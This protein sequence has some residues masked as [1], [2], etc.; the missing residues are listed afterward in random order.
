MPLF[1]P[2]K[3]KN[4]IGKMFRLFT[5]LLLMGSAVIGPVFSAANCPGNWLG[6]LKVAAVELRVV[7]RISASTDGSLMAVMD[8]PDQGAKNI[9]VDKVDCTSTGLKL[10]VAGIR[11]SFEGTFGQDGNTLSG[12]WQQG[13]V[14]IPLELKRVQEV[15]E[16]KRPQTP[17]KPYPYKEEE[18]VFENK[19]AGVKLAGTLTM[20]NKQEPV[21]GVILLS[22]SGPQDRDETIFN[23]KPFW[24][25]AD[26]LT[27]NGI[28]VLRFDDRGIGKSTGDFSQA[29]TEDF[30]GDALAAVEFLK[31]RKEIDIRKIGLIGHSEGGL[32]APLAA[33][34][35]TEVRFIVLLAGTGLPGE[36]ILLTQARLISQASGVS[37]SAIAANQDLQKRL[38]AIVKEE[39]DRVAAEKRLAE[40]IKISMDKGSEESKKA[41]PEAAM[42]AQ[43]KSVNSPWFR[44]F[45]TFDPRPILQ[46]V[47]CPTLALNG[48]KDL[49]V[50][51]KENLPA[52]ENALKTG[53]NKNYTVKELPGLNHLFQSCQSGTVAE[54]GKIEETFSPLA[55]KIIADWIGALNLQ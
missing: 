13:G 6:V 3:G 20:P 5:M 32:I 52:I 10:S 15:P 49:Q 27:R 39:K 31:T 16:A 19:S 38:F 17:Q 18:V 29:T 8:S 23:H 7:V 50:A 48:E 54:Y 53:G 24:V 2:S 25:L 47:S 36:D 40:A 14:S 43:I 22:G 12:T 30:S 55:M 9:P 37:E 28:A 1:A 26:Y 41:M 46:K 4:M 21:A 33:V 51:A 45:L 34:R 35:S 44:F 11:G 42:T